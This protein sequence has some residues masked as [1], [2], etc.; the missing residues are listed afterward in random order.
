MRGSSLTTATMNSQHPAEV[1]GMFDLQSLQVLTTAV[2]LLS[3]VLVMCVIIRL[4]LTFRSRYHFCSATMDDILVVAIGLFALASMLVMSSA[5][6]AGLGAHH[7]PQ[8]TDETSGFQTKTYTSS[9][10]FVIVVGFSKTSLILWLRQVE[11]RAVCRICTI[12]L[13]CAAFF[14]TIVSAAAL[15][16]QCQF[17]KLWD[18]RTGQCISLPLFWTISIATDTTLDLVLTVL[19]IVAVMGM[20]IQQ[21]NETWAI[22][23][24]ALR[25]LLIILSLM[26][27]LCLQQPVSDGSVPALQSVAYI[28]ATHCQVTLATILSYTPALPCFAVLVK[29][30]SIKA[31]TKPNKHWSGTSLDH[32]TSIDSSS[33]KPA[34]LV[35]EPLAAIQASMVAQ[36]GSP[37]GSVASL[38]SPGHGWFTK[39]PSRPPRPSENE[40]PDLSMF[41]R[42]PTVKKPPLVTL[43]DNR[44]NGASSRMTCEC[45]YLGKEP[46]RI[47]KHVQ[48]DV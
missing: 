43:L 31:P 28:I 1:E 21:R 25:T 2:W 34:I 19:P 16:F 45:G 9:V 12:S 36:I 46:V 32:N 24:L 33:S 14:C 38:A 15:V 39:A 6:N 7:I 29:S 11:L 26:R 8:N 5:V 47:P 18:V 23:I 3:T 22:S 41:T 4:L 17:S 13:G 30:R 40:R 44:S 35:R 27:L 42:K 48:F 10:L 20:S 37:Y